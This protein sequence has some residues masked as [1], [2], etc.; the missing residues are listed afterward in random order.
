MQPTVT[1]GVA[2][3]VCRSA[4]HD[5]E[6]WKNYWTEQEV[7]CVGDLGWPKE[8]RT[9]QGSKSPHAQGQFWGGRDSPS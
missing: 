2:W 8:P 9:R 1:E 3:S 4:C 6:P 7:V 5:N